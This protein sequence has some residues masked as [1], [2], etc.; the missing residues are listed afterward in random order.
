MNYSVNIGTYRVWLG[1]FGNMQVTCDPSTPYYE[2]TTVTCL[3]ISC[4]TGK[5]PQDLPVK[6]CLSCHYSCIDCDGA[7]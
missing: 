3:S 7:N 5:Y 1:Y 6:A 4:I 2:P